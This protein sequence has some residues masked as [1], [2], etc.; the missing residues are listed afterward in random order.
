MESGEDERVGLRL[1]GLGYSRAWLRMVKAVAAWAGSARTSVARGQKVACLGKGA[2]R[3]RVRGQTG[4]PLGRMLSARARAGTIPCPGRHA[5]DH[6]ALPG[7]APYAQRSG[8]MTIAGSRRRLICPAWHIFAHDTSRGDLLSS[9]IPSGTE[10]LRTISLQPRPG[11]LAAPAFTRVLT[12]LNQLCFVSATLYLKE[13][14]RHS[15]P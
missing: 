10:S 2:R 6:G 11:V 5:F 3:V 4:L 1:R 14:S 12:V 8:H 9:E 15:L 13:V 7:H